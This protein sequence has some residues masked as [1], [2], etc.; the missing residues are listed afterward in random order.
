MPGERNSQLKKFNEWPAS[1]F[2]CGPLLLSRAQRT[3]SIYESGIE[4]ISDWREVGDLGE[5]QLPQGR[6]VTLFSGHDIYVSKTHSFSTDTVL[7]AHFAA[8]KRRMICADF[9]TGCGAIPMIWRLR[10]GVMNCTG[11]E[12]QPAALQQAEATLLRNR[13][14]GDIR[15]IQ[16]DLRTYRSI[17]GHQEYDVIACNPPYKALGGGVESAAEARN[18]ARHERTLSLS[19]LARAAAFGLKFGGRLCLCQRPERLTDVMTTLRENAL[20]PKRLRLV[21]Q[22]AGTSPSLF[23]L[24]ARKGGHSGLEILPPLL[25][26]GQEGY[27]DEMRRIY[28]DNVHQTAGVAGQFAETSRRGG[29][30]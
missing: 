22:R 23:L 7:L 5:N 13:L 19:D 28:Q 29:A 4:Q 15:L 3:P 2:A 21:Q 8:P 1:A 26:E 12:L 9:G 20:E 24:E 16:G 14:S 27:S 30:V 6:W 10:F 25:I 17:L 11:I 18:T